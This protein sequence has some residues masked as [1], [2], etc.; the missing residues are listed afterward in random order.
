MSLR[1]TIIFV[2]GL[3]AWSLG[4]SGG[5]AAAQDSHHVPDA[6]SLERLRGD[7]LR[8]SYAGKTLYGVYK[9]ATSRSDTKQFT[10]SLSEDGATQY[11]EGDF[12]S[13][14]IWYVKHDQ[15][16]FEYDEQDRQVAHCFYEFRSGSCLYSYNYVANE[17]NTPRDP[18]NWLSKSVAKGD[19]STCDDYYG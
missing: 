1:K 5:F 16:C 17:G 18:A 13:G 8:A 7:A 19:Y 10:E 4:L 6:D 12:R 11:R 14:G 2:L 15:M 9:S 3:T